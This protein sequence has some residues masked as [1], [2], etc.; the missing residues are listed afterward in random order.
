[1]L[2]M[3]ISG[4]WNLS[5]LIFLLSSLSFSELFDFL[6]IGMPYLYIQE[7]AIRLY[8]NSEGNQYMC[9][10]VSLC[11]GGEF[12]WEIPGEKPSALETHW[13]TWTTE[14]YFWRLEVRDQSISSLGSFW[15]QM[16]EGSVPGPSPQL[17]MAIFSVSSHPLS[18]V[19]AWHPLIRT[20]G[21]LG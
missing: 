16:R 11:H 17:V 19:C 5:N 3:N 6:T 15:W 8:F 1:M 2:I 9:L 14:M 21:I 20:L 4:L 10:Y 7:K 18:S 12:A 13:V